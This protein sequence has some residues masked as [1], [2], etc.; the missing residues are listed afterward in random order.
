MGK[1]KGHDTATLFLFSVPIVA[2]TLSFI[3]SILNLY[4]TRRGLYGGES[5]DDITIYCKYHISSNNSHYYF[6]HKKQEINR[7]R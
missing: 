5:H 3:P 1:E 6:L 2:C 4:M 7:G